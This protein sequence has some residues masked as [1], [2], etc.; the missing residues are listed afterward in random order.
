M[1]Q[2]KSLKKEQSGV[3]FVNRTATRRLGQWRSRWALTFLVP[4]LALWTLGV[5]A[6]AAQAQSGNAA[7]QLASALRSRIWYED[8]QASVDG[9]LFG[10]LYVFGPQQVAGRPG[11]FSGERV[12]YRLSLA[13]ERT[14]F[15]WTTTVSNGVPCLVI[16][17]G[18]SREVFALTN[19]NALLE[20]L[21]FRVLGGQRLSTQTHFVG[22]RSPY[23]PAAIRNTYSFLP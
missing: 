15:A 12:T 11:W 18:V 7:T 3:G 21:T 13:A 17:R 1:C 6:P 20:V 5:G 10:Y 8:L 16:D 2:S 19:V 14:G 9:R 23:F 22:H 4:C